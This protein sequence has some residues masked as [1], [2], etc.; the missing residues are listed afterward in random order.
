MTENLKYTIKE[1]EE[2]FFFLYQDRD[3]LEFKFHKISNYSFSKEDSYNL[4]IIDGNC[5]TRLTFEQL[6]FI[7]N[8]IINRVFSI[9]DDKFKIVKKKELIGIYSINFKDVSK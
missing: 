4:T 5:P 3:D 9:F 6:E 1:L 2:L 7:N 8:D